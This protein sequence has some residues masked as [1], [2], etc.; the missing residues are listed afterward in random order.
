MAILETLY[1]ALPAPAAP[2]L[3]LDEP[4]VELLPDELEVELLLG[5]L[6]GLA[7]AAVSDLEPRL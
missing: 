1:F 4:E 6:A 7:P 5:E 2:E 3:L